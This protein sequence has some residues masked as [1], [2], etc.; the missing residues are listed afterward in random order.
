MPAASAS[1]ALRRLSPP[2]VASAVALVLVMCFSGTISPARA[3]D[4]TLDP[5][6]SAGPLTSPTP[7]GQT[8][9]PTAGADPSSPPDPW[10]T[11]DPSVTPG[12]GA[13]P[14][15]VPALDPSLVPSPAPPP[16]LPATLRVDHV[17]VD[18]IDPRTG[19]AVAG[20]LDATGIGL[21]RGRIYVVRFQ[22]VN[23]TDAAIEL[24]PVLEFALGGLAQS[25]V[26]VP[27]VDP[28]DGVAFYTSAN[29]RRGE[30]SGTE[31]VPVEELRLATSTDP[32]GLPVPG[33]AHAGVNPG[34][35]TTLA[36]HAF[37]ELAFTFR[38]TSAAEWLTAYSLR[39]SDAGAPI[40]G[41]G[42]AGVVTGARPPLRL[43]PGQ[44]SG[45]DVEPPV[46]YRSSQAASAGTGAVV[47]AEPLATSPHGPYTL[48]TDACG[49]C[50]TTHVAQGPMLLSRPS[51]QAGLCFTCHD[52]SPASNVAG[53]Y[54]DPA[55]P[56]N[57]PGT[58]SYYS[59]AATVVSSHVGGQ[60][61]SEFEGVLNRHTACADC[62]QPHLADGSP[63]VE[64]TNGWTASGALYGA[65]GVSVV[66]GSAGAAPTYTKTSTS[67]FE[68]QLCFKCHSGFTT[69]P[70]QTGPPSTWALDKAVELNPANLSYHPVEAPGRN[71]TAQLDLSLSGDVTW[72]TSPYKLW[73]F[74]TDSTIRCVSCHGDSRLGNPASP[75]DPGDRLAPHAV[76]NAGILIENLRTGS[77]KG[78][79]E[80]YQAADFA[81]CYVCH[82]EAPFVDISQGPLP[83][84]NFPL[85]G[86]HTAGIASYVGGPA[87]S[88]DDDGAGIGNALCAEC[89]FRTHG[90]AYAVDGQPAWSRL[91]NFGPNVQPYQGPDAL[92]AGRLEWE[93]A[94][95]SC[96]LTCHGVPHARW[97]Y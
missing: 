72:G 42:I 63:A 55:V 26:R 18:V 22:V 96:T 74:T 94:S 15:P 57:N 4:P 25:W 84:T 43:S 20:A 11:P 61:A 64:T 75:P 27:A 48:T 60:G 47:A 35:P 77:L 13:E 65:S 49:S 59:H 82:G 38:T 62:H 90:T 91:V 53:Q 89:H 56:A 86:F 32:A 54:S 80:A 58:G 73:Q 39:L 8:A 2:L 93:E 34:T 45:I 71:Q 33:L 1:R 67:T 44:R 23:G 21:E 3:V 10:V 87:G 51:P 14:S 30:Q 68:Y 29:V 78:G 19:K 7:P 41:T 36:P 50:H 17:W 95:G 52:G 70:E 76:A 97:S 16:Q 66:N 24:H 69:L 28:L 12:P 37:T 83:D 9:A 85:H 46:V 88:I 92:L 31:A 40:D 5:S 79:S 6:P 81:L